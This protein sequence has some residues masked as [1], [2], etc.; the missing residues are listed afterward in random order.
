[1]YTAKNSLFGGGIGIGTRFLILGLVMAPTLFF[2][3]TL[4]G[5]RD[6]RNNTRTP[7]P[8]DWQA[9]KS[10]QVDRVHNYVTATGTLSETVLVYGKR[11]DPYE[12]LYDD[13]TGVGILVDHHGKN[14]PPRS[15]QTPNMTLV[16]MLDSAPPLIGQLP[17][18]QYPSL[19]RTYRFIENK[20]PGSVG[21]QIAWMLGEIALFLLCAFLA[22]RSWIAPRLA[23]NNPAATAAGAATDWNQ[24]RLDK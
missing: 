24:F 4:P 5:L 18:S 16:G 7:R 17:A 13:K 22:Y 23:R 10:S 6:A 1:M 14:P 3:M 2:T 21:S 11:S 8:L 12:I 9:V 19:N 20:R 15:T